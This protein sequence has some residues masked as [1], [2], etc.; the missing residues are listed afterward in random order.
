MRL[1]L[2]VRVARN[3]RTV[4]GVAA[5][6]GSARTASLALL[7][8]L[9]S[10][11]APVPTWPA[12]VLVGAALAAAGCALLLARSRSGLRAIAGW[13]SVAV[14][15]R[16]VGAALVAAAFDA[17]RP[18]LTAIA[19][20]AAIELAATLPL[21]PGNVGLSSAAVA[22]VLAAQGMPGDVALAAG[23]ALALVE[24]ATS[25]AVGVCGV[26]YLTRAAAPTVDP[27]QETLTP[28]AIAAT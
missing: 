8:C 7:V 1:G 6:I 25:L 15:A 12:I 20:V 26:A 24:T 16:L 11:T 28:I 3:T 5:A 23:L 22:F 10:A 2:Y 14:V 19:I 9:A 27:P 21:T 4:A 18:L 17:P 13:V